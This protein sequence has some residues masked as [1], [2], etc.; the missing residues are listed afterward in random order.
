M[1]NEKSLTLHDIAEWL[2]CSSETVRRLIVGGAL[3]GFKVGNTWR[4]Y[5]SSVEVYIS[6]SKTG[7]V[8]QEVAA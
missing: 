4:A 6:Q 3:S 1:S 8:S 5:Q 7:E 2:N